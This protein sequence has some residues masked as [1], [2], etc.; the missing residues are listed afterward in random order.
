MAGAL[1]LVDSN[2]LLRWIKPDDRDYALVV[3]AIEIALRNGAVL[4]YTSQNVGGVLEHLHPPSGTQRI[5]PD[6][7]GGRSSSRHFRAQV[8]I[9]AG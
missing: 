6:S 2:I 3:S 4:C 9:V 7:N 8:A 1:Y 5:W